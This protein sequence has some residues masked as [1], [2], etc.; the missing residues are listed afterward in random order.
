MADDIE[1]KYKSAGEEAFKKSMEFMRQLNETTPESKAVSSHIDRTAFKGRKLFCDEKKGTKTKKSFRLVD[2]Y[3][4]LF[5]EPLRNSHCAEDDVIA[6]V[7]CCAKY[8][9]SI[10]DWFENNNKNFADIQPLYS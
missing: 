9:E 8:G 2:I 3:E 5:G 1:K 6:L 4:R 10:I 7:K